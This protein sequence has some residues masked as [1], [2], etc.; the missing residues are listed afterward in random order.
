MNK[1]LFIQKPIEQLLL[2]V[3]FIDKYLQIGSKYSER[4]EEFEYDQKLILTIVNDTGYKF[5][6]SKNKDF[7]LQEDVGDFKV[8]LGFSIRFSSFDFGISIKSRKHDIFT[9]APINYLIQLI[10]NDESTVPRIKFKNNADVEGI[11]CEFLNLYEEI[12]IELRSR[13][14]PDMDFYQTTEP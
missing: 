11:L 14:K 5:K 8:N 1:E 13:F 12:K 9:A 4:N 6:Y 7:Y 3:N 10:N 2:D